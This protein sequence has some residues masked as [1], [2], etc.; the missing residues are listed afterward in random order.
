MF[1]LLQRSFCCVFHIHPRG[2]DTEMGASREET[3][4]RFPHDVYMKKGLPYTRYKTRSMSWIYTSHHAGCYSLSLPTTT[5][6]WG[7]PILF[8]LRL[9]RCACKEIVRMVTCDVVVYIVDLAVYILT[10]CSSSSSSGWWHEI[11][12]KGERE[13]Y[14]PLLN[15]SSPRRRRPFIFPAFGL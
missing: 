9:W 11:G 8:F 5:H 10:V 14:S 7:P 15:Q 4:T 2:S 1:S 13:S 3:D 6:M 12:N